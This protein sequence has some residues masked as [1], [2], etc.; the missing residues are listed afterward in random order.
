MNSDERYRRD[1][2]A[3]GPEI[4]RQ[5]RDKLLEPDTAGRLQRDADALEAR[6]QLAGVGQIRGTGRNFQEAAADFL[7][8]HDAGLAAADAGAA[9]ALCPQ[10]GAYWACDCTANAVLPDSFMGRP[11]RYT[12][13]V[14]RSVEIF[15][16]IAGE[17]FTIDT[18]DRP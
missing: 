8:Q 9:P 13:D 16:T 18:S 10:C 15:E 5:L 7:R 14:P 3:Y 17:K 11:V 12:A 6:Y 1:A 2:Q 4:A